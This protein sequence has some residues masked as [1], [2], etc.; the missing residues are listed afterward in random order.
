MTTRFD[1]DV[2]VAGLL[3]CDDFTAPSSSVGDDAINASN[4]ITRAK[5]IQEALTPYTVDLTQLRVHDAL[6]TNL[7]GAA[8]NDDM[9]LIT[10]T[11]GTHAPRL[12][13]VD[14]G[15]GST[16]EKAA[17]V[18]ALPAEYDA[19]ETITIRVRAA[20]ITTIANGTCTVDVEC[21]KLDGDGAVGS[22]LCTT[23]AQSINSLTRANKDFTITPTGLAKG[24]QLMVRVSFAGT[25]S[26]DAGV[27]IP[28]IS[29][30]QML[31]DIRG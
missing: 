8:A 23:S 17:F 30:I 26:G 11:P 1:G 21:W 28:E 16:D 29:R 5:L 2:H 3:F 4:P 19:A 18:F 10:G 9:G 27:M 14:F 22:D 7:P 20:M 25:D 12:Q 15:G 31:L 6:H 24:D 13:G